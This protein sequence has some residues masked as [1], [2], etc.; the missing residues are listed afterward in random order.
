MIPGS[1]GLQLFLVLSLVLTQAILPLGA[2]V[3]GRDLGDASYDTITGTLL[4]Y[5]KDQAGTPLPGVRVRAT[6]LETGNFRTVL[7]NSEGL[8]QISFLPLGKYK[9]EALKDGFKPITSMRDSISIQLNKSVQFLPDIILGPVTAPSVAAAQPTT[10]TPPA[11]TPAPPAPVAGATEEYGGKLTNDVDATRRANA[12]EQSV[13]LL[14]LANVRS[15]D[16]LAL[17]AAGVAPPPQVKGVAGPGIGAGIGTA[18]QFS[19]NGQRARSNNFTVD[20]SDNNDEDV[21][22]RRQ[23]FVALVPQSIESVKEVQIVTHLWDAE[24]GRSMGSQV[25]AVS[26]SGTNLIHGAA[27]DFFNHSALN[28]RNYF[29]YE[30]DKVKSYPLTAQAIGRY[31]NGQPVNVRTI[32]VV[33]RDNSSQA[34]T[35]LVQPN[36]SGG[37]DKYQRNQGGGVLGFPI[38]RDKTFFFGSFERQ[39]IKAQQETHFS[40]PTVAQRGFLGF[41]A[42]GFSASDRQGRQQVFTPTSLAGDGVMSLFPFPNNPI[43]PYGDNTFSQIL[44]SDAR[45]TIFS[46]KLD[47][48]FRLFGP[49]VTHAFTARYNFTDDERQVPAV[50]GAI[51]SG[52]LPRVRTQNLS[53]FLNSQLS[54]SRANQF[55]ASYGRTA[56]DFDELRDPR[57]VRSTFLP[58]EPFLVNAPTIGNLSSPD[59]PL[60]F[61]DYRRL[62]ETTEDRLATIG[63]VVVQPFSPIGLDVYLFPQ[64]RKNN[65]IQ[66]ADTYSIFRAQH[67][68][69]LGVDIRRT[70][71]NSFQNRN[72][73]P[74]V[75]F[76]GSPDLTNL[77]S[78]APIPNISQFGPTPGF[79]SGADLASLG[80]P[81]GIFQS[82]A[83]G[84]PDS[85]IGL[86]LWQLNG[87]VNDNWRA[88]RG[89]TLDY[90]VRYEINTVPR[91]VNSRIENTFGLSGLPTADQNISIAAP[92]S[93]GKIIF[94]NQDLINS[95]NATVGALRAQIGDRDSIFASDRNN[96]GGHAGFAWDPFAADAKRAGKT[97]VRGG[98]GLYYD[99]TLGSVVSQ[100]RNVFPTFLPF[101]VDVNTFGYARDR[102]FIPGQTGIYGIFN[103]RYVPVTLVNQ[104]RATTSGL[105]RP[106]QLNTIQAPAGALPQLLGLL[107][108]PTVA[109]VLPSGGGIAY[110]LPDNDLRA[111]YTFQYNLQIEREIYNDFLLNLAYVGTR[112][113]KLTR[114]RTPN[115][116]PNSVTLPIDPLGLTDNPTFAIALPPLSNIAASRFSRPNPNLG[117]YT[118]FDSS[119]S[120][121]YHSMQLTAT[122]RFTRGYQL[123][124]AYTWSHA[125]DDVS[126]VFDVAG[127]Y[128]LPQDDRNLALERG[129]ANFDIRHRLA[130]S[131]IGDLPYLSQFNA[132]PGAAGVLLGGW[133][134]STL[135]TFQTGQPFTVNSGYDVNLDGNLTDRIDTLNGLSVTDSGLQKLSLNG[136]AINLL[137][138]LGANGRIGRNLFR[139]NG[140]ARID[141]ALM[142][143]FRVR[144][145]QFVI[146]R[147]EAFNLANRT[148]FGIP[149]R[150]L[151]APTFGRSVDTSIGSRQIQFALKYVF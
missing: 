31:A 11:T 66:V 32:P 99:L 54:P 61:V 52:V 146:F 27:Y 125:I 127:A 134:F 14:P 75:V 45:A 67:A 116:G 4:G 58:N 85:T 35:G 136:S 110:T 93:D 2:P 76:G 30:D 53:L 57:L 98:V 97:S 3:F 6:N 104:G 142:K 48:N 129:S 33:L 78:S 22:V 34:A 92:F 21:G 145:G 80:I 82:L 44:P 107:F 60:P 144:E 71:L 135:A 131:S 115:G 70:Q 105:L 47:H 69:K 40:V 149:V 137:A 56:L 96:F 25:N 7:S 62:N 50:G 111:P 126:D 95:F 77:F 79:F 5:V 18:G 65:T 23:G 119:A 81:T 94:R 90:G 118:V 132:R 101:N 83:I 86:R 28:A 109:G 17:L 43:G 114:F 106:D 88:R 124:A 108:N 73:R 68:Y 42:S 123:S 102:F 148:H 36:P 130:I 26:K 147:A 84:T 55:R 89:L 64:S 39:D 112:G 120:S 122:K 138:P 128:V 59:V 139:A 91:E 37:Q 1:K 117:S 103:P 20:G 16:D 74:Q 9:V 10:P 13:S 49:E 12:D 87:F 151:E 19:V 72:Y 121:I 15:F 29:D 24:Q 150:I 100:S 51:Y 38:L 140:V 41:G 46:L 63:Q 113:L 133:Q 8:Y 141:L 143:N